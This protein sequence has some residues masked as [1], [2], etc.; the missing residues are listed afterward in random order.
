MEAEYEVETILK[1]KVF[2]RGKKMGWKFYVKWK[3]YEDTDNTWE[4]FKSFENCGENLIERFWDRV[5]TKGRDLDS[6]EGWT[7]GEEIV[8][9]GPPRRKSRTTPRKNERVNT[10]SSTDEHPISGETANGATTKGP[11]ESPESRSSSKRKR[12]SSRRRKSDT[13]PT[14]RPRR[15]SPTPVPD[16]EPQDEMLTDILPSTAIDD[17]LVGV[18]ASGLAEQVDLGNPVT[19]SAPEL[20][21]ETQRHSCPPSSSKVSNHIDSQPSTQTTADELN[22][23][24]TPSGPH[25]EADPPIEL[26]A[27]Q[28]RGA[29]NG[30]KGL[31]GRDSS[32]L[33]YNKKKGS[34]DTLRRNCAVKDSKA[35]GDAEEVLQLLE[36]TSATFSSMVFP[37]GSSIKTSLQDGDGTATAAEQTS[38]GDVEFRSLVDYE[39]QNRPCPPS[40]NI[41]L[42]DKMPTSISFPESSSSGSNPWKRTT[43]FGPLAT[44]AGLPTWVTSSASDMVVSSS[45]PGPFLLSLDNS[46]SVPVALKDISSAQAIHHL[47]LESIVSGTPG[48]PGKLYTSDAA[49]ALLET[50]ETGGPCA[51]LVPGDTATAEQR[52][53]FDA[54]CTKLEEGGLFVVMASSELLA[55]CSSTNEDYTKKLALA[56]ALRGLSGTVVVSHIKVA[57]YSAFADAAEQAESVR[58]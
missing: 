28:I 44:G 42:P 10:R 32:L 57:N 14:R 12:T 25:P 36:S 35:V 11:L 13:Q 31:K 58:W 37:S 48:P 54:F 3:G 46:I 34:L 43:I 15:E 23:S 47:Q 1:A 5:D 53:M 24:V 9:I 55:C 49:T 41:E 52:R 16:S 8:P 17:V 4:P 51:R 40:P 21:E 33:T 7:N 27:P 30:R 19:S 2:M 50:L 29:N 26:G 39:E 20:L 22:T 38:H 18:D 6:I 56:A 45:S